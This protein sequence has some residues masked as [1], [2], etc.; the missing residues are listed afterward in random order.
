MCQ[1]VSK[2]F[3]N[4]KVHLLISGVYIGIITHLLPTFDPN[5][6][7]DI[8]VPLCWPVQFTVKFMIFSPSFCHEKT[9]AGEGLHVS[10]LPHH[11]T[12][13]LG[14]R[15]NSSWSIK[16][17]QD[18]IYWSCL[19]W[20]LQQNHRAWKRNLRFFEGNG[21]LLSIGF[22]VFFQIFTNRQWWLFK[23]FHPFKT[24]WLYGSR[25]D[26]WFFQLVGNGFV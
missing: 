23:Y 26:K 5:F 11:H 4:G 24:G 25:W 21:L 15:Y 9:P 6:Q 14:S 8:Q 16:K 13:K 19:R 12:P 1:E 7:P 3:V 20:N 22:D 18:H 2:R 10:L 17:S